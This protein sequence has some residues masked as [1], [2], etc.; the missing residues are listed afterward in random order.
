M[1]VQRRR[2]LTG[3]LVTWLLSAIAVFVAAKIV[4]GVA[5]DTFGAALA[6]AAVLGIVNAVVRPIL[7][8]LTLPVTVLTL[9]LFLLVVNGACVG[10]AARLLPGFHVEGL[11]PAI[12]MVIVVS[13]VS[14]VL[15]WLV[16]D[17]EKKK[18]RD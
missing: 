2:G 18:K 16:G 9:G 14:G 10:L 11:G 15:G 6:A 8:L 13:M 17:D 3:L 7:V 12:L 4:P 5:V 1:L